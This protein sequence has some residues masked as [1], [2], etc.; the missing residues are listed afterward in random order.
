MHYTDVHASTVG[1]DGQR[2]NSLH[3]SSRKK[4]LVRIAIDN[5][6]LLQRIQQKK[7]AYDV[8]KWE[9]DRVRQ[10]HYIKNICE[11]TPVLLQQQSGMP[12]KTA[13]QPHRSM[14]N[15]QKMAN[16]GSHFNSSKQVQGIINNQ[17]NR[18]IV[19]C[20]KSKKFGTHMFIVEIYIQEELLV[21]QLENV[22]LLQRFQY[23]LQEKQGNHSVLYVRPGLPEGAV[24]EQHRGAGQ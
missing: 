22:K 6:K 2:Q 13:H 19:I 9:V 24:Q 10:E 14:H 15:L 4:E 17:V 7:S 18:K 3:Q 21:I 12:S 8:N 23:L 20:R 1:P 11:Y 16:T 5:Q